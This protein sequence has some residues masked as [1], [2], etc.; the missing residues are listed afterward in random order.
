MKYKPIFFCLCICGILS[1]MQVAKGQGYLSKIISIR[2]E[3][4]QLS[5]AL[6][7]L[8]KKGGFYFSYS[9]DIIPKDSLINFTADSLNVKEVLDTLLQNGFDYK[10]AP[11]YII[12]RRAPYNLSLMAES[13]TEK[14]NAYTVSGYVIDARTGA[15]IGQASVYDKR[16]L[17]STLTDQAGFFSFKA[18]NPEN[19]IALTATKEYYKDITVVIL[20]S[21]TVSQQGAETNYGYEVD[22]NGSRVERTAFGR[23]FISSRQKIQSLNLANFFARTPFQASLTPGLSS[24]GMLSSQ[25]INKFSLNLVGGYTAG[26]NGVEW[27][28]VFNINKK[29]VR[30]FQAA[31]VFNIVGGKVQGLQA[32]GVNNT[33]LDSVS[34]V[35]LTGVYNRVEGRLQGLQAA[36]VFNQVTNVV[37]G[38]QFAGVFNMVTGRVAGVQAAGLYNYTQSSILGVQLAG[39]SNLNK[40]EVKGVQV[41]GA[42][43]T[44]TNNLKGMQLAGA[45]NISKGE[46]NGVQ[47]AGLF[48]YARQ[49][50]GVQIGVINIADTS[51]GVSIGILNFIRGGYH[52]VSVS[53]NEITNTNIA[54]KTGNAKLY[55]ILI[56]GAN[57][58]GSAKV[59]AFGF[60]LGH[61][62]IFN[63]RFSLSAELSSQ[64][65]YLGDWENTLSLQ[66]AKTSLNLQL[67]KGLSIFVGP[68]F[69]I[70]PGPA[71][72]SEAGYKKVVPSS[73]YPLLINKANLKGWIGWEAGIT[74]F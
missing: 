48:N 65:L 41:A 6:D 7:T 45:G 9:S 38:T 37:E 5:A 71:N 29:S 53:S 67:L 31:S 28:G 34:G 72:V 70:N 50:K 4:Q 51:S 30:Y 55:S 49:L 2:I 59:Y 57:L 40:G 18:K 8:S 66:R 14:D 44:T 73:S 62:F 74:L 12:L 46:T 32:S 60:G 61:D 69:S 63:K 33:V 27:A 56:A 16:L 22:E 17:V 42:F 3:Q 58:S 19:A 64:T 39:F 43:N 11:R 68:A 10:E 13:V 21:V 15:G 52:K 23:F 36:G 25:V 54:F 20:S 24:H 35:Q 1:L 47:L 26:V